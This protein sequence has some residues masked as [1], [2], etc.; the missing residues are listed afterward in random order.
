MN[1]ET[2]PGPL[3]VGILGAG[4]VA[5]LHAEAIAASGA[6]RLV[7]V[8][9]LDPVRAADLA[10]T[11]SAVVYPDLESMLTEAQLDVLHLCTPPASHAAQAVAA[12]AA[13]VHVVLEKPPALSLTELDEIRDAAA[14]A[15]RQLVIVFQQRTGSAASHVKALLDSGALGR[16]FLAICHTLWH[17]A[18]DYYSVP[19]RGSWDTEG[20][21]TTLGHGIHQ[22]DLLAY[23]VG[24][25]SSV[26]GALWRLDRDV[27]TED[28]SIATITFEN[29]AIASM[30]TSVLSARQTSYVRIDTELA[31]I[32]VE[33]LY[34]HSRA[35]W[36]ITASPHVD[37]AVAASWEFPDEDIPSSHEALI[38]AAYSTLTTPG[39]L[40]DLLSSPSRSL[41]IVSAIYASARTGQTITRA[42]LDSTP[43]LRGSLRSPV[44]ERDGS[45]R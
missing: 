40:P 16:P 33:H 9:D 38:A 45:L 31:T 41:E 4:A 36:N 24:E 17:R 25:W 10:A 20:G 30:V 6:G 35:N 1:T 15:D 11:A 21:G 23:L 28:T 29:G 19:W 8:S 13:G 5:R 7:A 34:G 12:F 22:L 39:A 43:A 26:S 2:T 42:E 44:R 3:R 14:R 32:E 18:E 37:P 27:E